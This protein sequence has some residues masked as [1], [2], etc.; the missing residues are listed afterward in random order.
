M[1]I[2]TQDELRSTAKAPWVEVV[3]WTPHFLDRIRRKVINTDNNPVYWG[4]STDEP[5]PTALEIA[6][7]ALH[8]RIVVT[9]GEVTVESTQGRFRLNKRDYFDLPQEGARISNIG[10]STA[11]FIQISGNWD[12]V[13]RTEIC[14]FGP[15]FPCDYHFHDGHE[16]WFPYQGHFTLQYDERDHPMKP[17]LIFAA[18]RGHEHGVSAPEEEFRAVVIATGLQEPCRDGHL[19]RALHGEPIREGDEG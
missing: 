8:D 11:E 15:G 14:A 18:R 6:P 12:E 16:Y 4:T 17:G 5:R 3:D 10:Y 1:P 19:T 9:S 7:R 2:Y 13:V